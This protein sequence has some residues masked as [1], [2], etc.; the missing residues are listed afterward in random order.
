LIDKSINFT[1][2]PIVLST[3]GKGRGSNFNLITKLVCLMVVL[4]WRITDS[5]RTASP[6][7]PVNSFSVENNGFNADG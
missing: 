4:W 6:L 2:F 1:S 5:T 3:F 7:T